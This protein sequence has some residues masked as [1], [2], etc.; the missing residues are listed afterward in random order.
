MFILNG[1]DNLRERVDGL[2]P[3]GSLRARFA[4]GTFRAIAGVVTSQLRPPWKR[5]ER[6]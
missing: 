4:R 5:L 2:L 1:W 6:I 3:S